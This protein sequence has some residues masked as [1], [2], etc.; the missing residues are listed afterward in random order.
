MRA[1]YDAEEREMRTQ[2][3]GNMERKIKTEKE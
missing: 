2:N 1:D 3:S